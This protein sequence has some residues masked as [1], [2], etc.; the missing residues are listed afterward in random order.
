MCVRE[1]EGEIRLRP[2]VKGGEK[3][4]RRRKENDLFGQIVDDKFGEEGEKRF[5]GFDHKILAFLYNTPNSIFYPSILLYEFVTVCHL[6][7]KTP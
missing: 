3:N 1:Q 7:Q 2:S 5:F 6:E 4:C